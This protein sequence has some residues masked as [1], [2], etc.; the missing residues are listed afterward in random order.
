MKIRWEKNFVIFSSVFFLSFVAYLVSEGILRANTL[1]AV[2]SDQPAEYGRLVDWLP[3]KYKLAIEYRAKY[4]DLKE[5]MEKARETDVR[6]DAMFNF[7]DYIKVKDKDE[8]DQVF[9]EVAKN[10]EYR[11][12]RRA[13]KS[14][15]RLLLN[16]DNKYQSL[17][18]K[19]Y[20]DHIDGLTWD[21][22]KMQAW[23]AG[24]NQLNS[25]RV[26]AQVHLD[27]LMPLMKNKMIY[28]N[29]DTF[30]GNIQTHA[31]NLKNAELVEE[32]KKVRE[33]IKA[34]KR[35]IPN[36][37]IQAPLD[38]RKRYAEYKADIAKADTPESKL[39]S[40]I[41]LASLLFD[42]DNSE[43]SQ[44][45]VPLRDNP[46]YVNCTNYYMLLARML[47]EKRVTKQVTMAEYQQYID[48]LTDEQ[49]KLSA[50]EAGFSQ[51]TGIKASAATFVNYLK[52]LIE[53]EPKYREYRQFIER[54]EKKATEAKD[55]ATATRAADMIKSI[56]EN[57]DIP[58]LN[59]Q[60]RI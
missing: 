5:K 22:D 54:L 48:S 51:L 9:A 43:A 23:T 2:K 24:R 49:T 36:N 17:S 34:A 26:S 29:F 13:Y 18:I 60:S 27:Y 58:W 55:D 1:A 41:G 31:N 3:A 39:S 59:P 6:V 46:E 14:L 42:K 37:I 57:Y 8:S 16:K 52:P 38:F 44:L 53:K 45:L 10:P 56:N 30:Y 35:G 47:L 12:S 33:E 50:W 21:E 32:A 4:L 7:A 15:A 19:E 11:K 25:L 20:H 28:T 40:T